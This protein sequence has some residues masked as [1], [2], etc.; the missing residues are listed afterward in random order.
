[1]GRTV[2]IVQA[3]MGSTRLPGKCLADIAG[4]P[5]LQHVLERLG[6]SKRIDDVVVATTRNSA[7]TPILDLVRQ[8]GLRACAGSEN[9]V[10]ARYL[11]AARF[12]KA[13]IIVRVTA[14]CPLIDPALADDVIDAYSREHGDYASNVIERTFPRGVET[15]VFSLETLRRIN[16]LSNQPFEREHVT[17]Y[18]YLHPED[19]KLVSITAAGALRRP[20]LRLCVDTEDDLRLVRQIYTRLSGQGNTFSMLDTIHAI[21]REPWLAE[22]NAHIEQK[23]LGE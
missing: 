18:F 17:P 7:D 4:K 13:E 22:I 6:L 9:D 2:A 20:D 16:A 5:M 15:E 1:M 8:V 23:K 21:E 3:R 14:D 19:F 10:L 12:A 11:E